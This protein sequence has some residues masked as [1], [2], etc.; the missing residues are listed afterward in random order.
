MGTFYSPRAIDQHQKPLQCW[1]P[2]WVPEM[3]MAGEKLLS[4]FACKGAKARESIYYINDGAGLRL[5]IRPNGSKNWIFRY[6][7]NA[8][9]R[10]VGLGSY[11]KVT[12][13]IARSK[14][15]ECR[16]TIGQG[17][18]PSIERKIK[19]TKL[20]EQENQTFGSIT[21]EW[22]DHNRGDWTE[23]HLTENE[24]LL[25]LYLLPDLGRLPI[26]DIEESYLFAILKPVY[27]AG[28]KESARRSRSIAAAIFAFAKDTHRCNHN[29][30]RDMADNSYFKK[31][32]VRHLAAL[33]QEDVPQLVT[34]LN[35]TGEEQRLK[36][37]TVCALL[38]ALY[39]GL[40][41]HSIRGAKWNEIDFVKRAWTVPG[42]RM[43]SGTDHRTP[44]PD[45]AIQALKRLKP[46]TLREDTSFVFSA[47]TK[48]G[49][50]AENTL[51]L[52]LH[53]LGFR[54]TTHGF[55]SLMTDVLNE[56]GF[57]RDAIERQLDHK[58]PNK[59]RR[60]YLRS[61]FWKE[62]VDMLQWFADWCGNT[63]ESSAR[64]ELKIVK[65]N[66]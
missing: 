62:R 49:Y 42:A 53:R 37:H 17:R 25:K 35:K 8:K 58:E 43:K 14:A 46:I 36:P 4:E 16:E 12:L 66:I 40:R 9:E 1:V 65:S 22:I 19:R 34:E 28:K 57:N 10:N 52:A 47:N 3:Q 6:R 64:P 26:K 31:P 44:L 5:R 21:R 54:V 39:T 18:N 63:Q 38:L 29:P 20:I 2:V 30:A 7:L 60:A 41:D 48:S 33:P 61:D 27:E 56:N 23:K 13:S 24:G 45:Q 11:P 59:I 32:I 50:I 51:R 15:A 55:R